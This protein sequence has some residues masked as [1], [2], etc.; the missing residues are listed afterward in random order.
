MAEQPPPTL[1]ITYPTPP[2]FYKDFTPENIA[3][4]EEL[5]AA[6]IEDDSQAKYSPATTLPKRLLDLPPELRCL[7]PPEPPVDG[8]YRCFG[9]DHTVRA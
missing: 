7:Q 8:F 5:R 2:P 6:K 3:R 4:I 9:I 1:T